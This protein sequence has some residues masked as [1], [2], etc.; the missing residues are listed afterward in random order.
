MS[1][2]LVKVPY[3]SGSK[4][5]SLNQISQIVPKGTGAPTNAEY[6][7]IYVRETTLRYS[8][9]G[10]GSL[11]LA[12]RSDGDVPMSGKHHS[13]RDESALL[14]A[15]HLRRVQLVHLSGH[16]ASLRRRQDLPASLS[17]PSR[18]LP[19]VP[20]GR[21]VVVAAVLRPAR[22]ARRLLAHRRP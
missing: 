18:A 2:V 12:G 20:V 21:V 9:R 14:G 8:F 3:S 11:S 17:L 5:F 15:R 13:T 1:L 19:A 7:V 10:I 22:V 6:S 4:M 16:R